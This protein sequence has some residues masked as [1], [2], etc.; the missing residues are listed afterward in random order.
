[1]GEII[2][3]A[4]LLKRPPSWGATISLDDEGARIAEFW[5]HD[6][7]EDVAARCRQWAE[8]LEALAAELRTTADA[9]EANHGRS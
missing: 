3:L 1:M 8:K 6:G 9:V 7:G 2:S 4:E 5:G